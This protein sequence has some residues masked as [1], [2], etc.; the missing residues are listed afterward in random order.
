MTRSVTYATLA[1]MRDEISQMP[2]SL[3]FLLSSQLDK[4][5]D[6]NEMRLKTL[7]DNRLRLLNEYA[8]KDEA[9]NFQ[10]E[11][12]EEKSVYKFE[13]E[14]RKKEYQD[15]YMEFMNRQIEIFL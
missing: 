9:G 15:K 1:Q 11:M 10:T 4:F 8:L 2:I 6:R 12:L 7:E 14:E 13:S 5:F 3:R